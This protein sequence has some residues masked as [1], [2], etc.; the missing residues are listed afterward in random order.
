M[1]HYHR[2]GDQASLNKMYLTTQN[3][4]NIKDNH[5]RTRLIHICSGVF[6]VGG[7]S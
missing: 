4:K 3:T 5:L 1:M 7:F 2:T 6:T